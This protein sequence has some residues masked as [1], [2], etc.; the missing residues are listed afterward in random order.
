MFRFGLIAAKAARMVCVAVP[1]ADLL[2]AR[3]RLL[4]L[5]HKK[6]GLAVV[7]VADA[8]G[9]KVLGALDLS[10]YGPAKMG[11]VIS[12]LTVT[13]GHAYLT[14]RGPRTGSNFL[15][16]VDVRDPK[17]PRWVMTHDPRPEL[18]DSPCLVWADFYQDLI[19]DGD[20]LFLGDYGEIQCLDISQPARPRWVEACHVGFQWSVGRKRGP[21]LFVPA[22]TGLLVLRAPSSSQA[23]EGKVEAKAR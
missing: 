22:L 2:C 21:H 12:G 23:P 10:P 14:G 13:K 16:V 15:H 9:A 6:G 17:R 4:Y 11:E 8:G 19:A 3:G 18:P 1:E 5:G 7:D 20:Y